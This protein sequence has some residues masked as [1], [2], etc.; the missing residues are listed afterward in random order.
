MC[1]IDRSRQQRVAIRLGPPLDPWTANSRRYQHESEFRFAATMMRKHRELQ[2]FS[3][4][5][6]WALNSKAHGSN[7]LSSTRKSTRTGVI[8]YAT[9]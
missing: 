8:S 9:E 7:P 1:T 5:T 6:R 2:F 4:T 3:G